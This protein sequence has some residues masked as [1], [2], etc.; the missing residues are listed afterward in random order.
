M[1]YINSKMEVWR[2]MC[3]LE[4]TRFLNLVKNIHVFLKLV[5]IHDVSL[6]LVIPESHEYS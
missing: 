6:N 3:L 2:E 5:N 1:Q 4:S